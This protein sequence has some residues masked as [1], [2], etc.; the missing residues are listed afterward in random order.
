[1]DTWQERGLAIA[2]SNTVEKNK[3]GWKV[4]SQ[5][6]NGTYVVNL[7]DGEPFCTCQHFEAT[8]N[9]CQHIYAVEFIV[10]REKRPDGTEVVTKTTRITYAQDWPVYNEAQTHEQERFVILLRDLCDGIE[11]PEYKFGRPRLPLSDVVFGLV[12][13]AYGTMSGRR[14]TCE[15]KEAESRGL[16]SKAAHYNSAFRYLENPEL[17]P[18]LK[19]L[20]EQSASPL[21]IVETDFAV[22]SSGFA[23]TT[24]ARWFDHKWGKERTRQTWVKAHLMC[25]VNTH[26]VTSAEATA[27]ESADNLQFPMLV[28]KTAEIFAINE[29][30][31]DKAYSGR[32]NLKVVQSVGGTAYI[33]F[34][35][36]STG[37][38]NKYHKYHE[39]DGLWHRMWHFYNFNREAFM[40]HCHKRSN[41]ETVYSMIKMKFGGSVRSKTPV[42]QVN[43]VLCKIL[44]H[45]ICVLI[46]SVYELGIEP[47]F[48]TFE[49]KEPVAPKVLK[50]PD[51]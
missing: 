2:E 44:C 3:L 46:Q 13:K 35:S 18:L 25:G 45:N 24:Y 49:A 1:M 34:M 20:I 41:A 27:Y 6:G 12:F 32:N 4:P 14:F 36:H 7:E 22:D 43:E 5:S 39:F 11:Q 42:A 23:T 15:L 51:F 38:I 8:H 47:T 21:R 26:I 19:S 40:Q 48:W 50:N 33:P 29:V 37:K 16:I 10:Q 31:A 17:T 28:E 30:S 9:K